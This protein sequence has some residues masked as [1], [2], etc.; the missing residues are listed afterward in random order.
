[1]QS[2]QLPPSLQYT[3]G[4]TQKVVK[5]MDCGF[6]SEQ[7]PDRNEWTLTHGFDPA[8]QA[9]WR[10]TWG[11]LEITRNGQPCSLDEAIIATRGTLEDLAELLPAEGT[12]MD[13]KD[14]EHASNLLSPLYRA[15]AR[16]P[17][18]D[19]NTKVTEHIDA[20]AG[21][22]YAAHRD[23]KPLPPVEAVVV[24]QVSGGVAEVTSCPPGVH[25]E[26]VDHDNEEEG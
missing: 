7:K 10:P 21:I 3:S 6:H 14:Y 1:M 12:P 25:V 5:L 20:V 22:F 9:V 15:A 17:D 8:I 26:I 19:T 11:T 2:T 13:S 18:P 16:I 4:V 23:K 24:V